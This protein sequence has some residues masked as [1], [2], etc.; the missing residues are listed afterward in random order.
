MEKKL[1]TVLM[2]VLTGL[3]FLAVGA[4]ASGEKS[5]VTPPKEVLIKDAA[6][7]ENKRTVKLTTR[8]TPSKTRLSARSAIMS[9]KTVKTSGRKGT[10]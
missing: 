4:M 10:P 9:S 8:S 6:F 1:L 2:V 5:N 3:L 7:K